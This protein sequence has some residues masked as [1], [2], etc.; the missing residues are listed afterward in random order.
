MS[1][2]L[3]NNPLKKYSG[4]MKYFTITL[5]LAFFTQLSLSA[6]PVSGSNY[7]QL[8]A[9]AELAESLSDYYNAAE[10]YELSYKEVRDL[11]VAFKI[12][13]LHTQLRNYVK[14]ERWWARLVN[15]RSTRKVRNTFMPEARFDYAKA[16]KMQ[17]KYQDAIEHFQLYISE[18]EDIARIN[19]AKNQLAGAKMALEMDEEPGITVANAGKKV[20]SKYS[21]ASPVLV[22]DNQLYFAGYKRDKLLVIDGKEEDVY[23]NIYMASKGEEGFT[24]A[25]PVAGGNLARDGYH[26]GN[27]TISPDG[28]KMFFTRATL[29]GNKLA[30]S[31]LYS[32]SMGANGWG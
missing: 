28:E 22:N 6:Q 3:M 29:N 18:S 20:N 1:T 9:S 17:G 32:S 16:L 23:S 25:E 27:L 19:L 14:A 26:L 12:A 8:M 7:D 11:N 5:L 10:Y 2:L 4:S 15:R 31:E 24:E 30:T 13:S 21:E